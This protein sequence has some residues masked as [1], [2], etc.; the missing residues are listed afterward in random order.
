M[1]KV[2]LLLVYAICLFAFN[3]QL[4][5]D[6]NFQLSGKFYYYPFYSTDDPNSAFN[7]VFETPSHR[8]FQ[9]MGTEPTQDNVFGWKEVKNINID[10][11]KWFFF[12]LGDFD[13]D[14]DTRFDWVITPTDVDSQVLYKLMEVTPQE[15]YFRYDGPYIVRYGFDGEELKVGR[16]YAKRLPVAFREHGYSN[17]NKFTLITN[18]YDLERFIEEI[19]E[20]SSWNDKENFIQHLQKVDFS[21]YN[22][23][24][25]S[26][27]EPSGSI[28]VKVEEERFIAPNVFKVTIK[29]QVPELGTSDMAY[30]ALVYLIDKSTQRFI[31]QKDEKEEIF[32]LK[33]EY[34]CEA[35]EAP[36]C[37]YRPI[38]CITTPCPAM[39]VRQE[40][41]KNYCELKKAGAVYISDGT[42]DM[43]KKVDSIALAKNLNKFAYNLTGDIYNGSG[44]ILLSP[45]SIVRAIEM[46]YFGAAGETKDE[47]ESILG[48]DLELAKS[49]EELKIAAASNVIK[50]ANALWFEKDMEIFPSYLYKLDD[51]TNASIFSADFLN[52]A[53]AERD[54]INRWVKEQTKGKIVDLLPYGSVKS[55][56]RA[57]LVNALYF[58]GAWEMPFDELLTSRGRFFSE[59]GPVWVDMMTQT[60]NFAFMQNNKL[61]AIELPYKDHEFSMFIFLPKGNRCI[62]DMIAYLK[63]HSLSEVRSQMNMERVLVRLPKFKLNWGT[64]DLSTNLKRIGFTTLFDPEHAN[65]THLG[66]PLDTDGKLYLKFLFHKAYLAVDEAGSEG[67]AATAGGVVEITSATPSSRQE[68]IVDHNFLFLIVDNRTDAI[69][70]LGGIKRL[71]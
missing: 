33:Q 21:V 44:N 40:T 68:F 63:N 37:G 48:K 10:N 57:L 8:V 3:P 58:K 24:I 22:I 26:F 49:F 15:H 65:L 25:Y 50:E 66:K 2:I 30:Y 47:I 36:V 59:N 71:P 20:Q 51:F 38:E 12:Y 46:I 56:M 28:Q 70:F 16:N 60:G 55:D 32:Q 61:K 43:E 11:P 5:T 19:R 14:G 23:L 64:K 52:R 13:N 45:Y 39:S 18:S 4:L 31:V 1:K 7:W 53:E 67:V 27:E 69:L 35:V 17:L 62:C 41:F 54:R 42:C 9:L 6:K 34:S 29:T